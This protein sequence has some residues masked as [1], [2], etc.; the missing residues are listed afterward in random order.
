MSLSKAPKI[1]WNQQDEEFVLSGYTKFSPRVIDLYYQSL[2]TGTRIRIS[3]DQV[4]KS[5]FRD[6]PIPKQD[7][8]L[9]GRYEC[10]AAALAIAL[11]EKLF[12]VKRQ[13]G[14]LLW[15]NDDSGVSDEL[16]RAT[17]RS[18]GRDLVEIPMNE[19]TPSL[20]PSI[21]TVKSLNVSGYSH[22]ITWNGQELLDPNTHYVGR[23]YWGADWTPDMIGAT[24]CHLL[25]DHV[26]SEAETKQYEDFLK[27]GNAKI[28]KKIEQEILLA[29]PKYPTLE[30]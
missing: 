7:P 21:L 3:P 25:M 23:H 18:L 28:I 9:Q 26:L 15:R 29:L 24:C 13:M 16:M 10:V 22:A 5:Y 19:V 8:I 1:I 27:E 12:T 14:K 30:V 11:G 17:A 6:K 4:E 2:K 20:G